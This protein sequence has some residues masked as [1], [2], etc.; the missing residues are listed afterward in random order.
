MHGEE[1]RQIAAYLVEAGDDIGQQRPVDERRAVQG[2]E[3]IVAQLEA[4]GDC[5]V[6]VAEALLHRDERVDHR[7]ADEVHP[8][9][10][11]ALGAQV[12]D[13]LLAMQEQVLGELVG[14]DAVDLL[15][16][17]AVEGAQARLQ[18]TIFTKFGRAP[19]T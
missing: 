10:G 14:D 2:D 19:T 4:E 17:R 16:H 15:G 8:L 13:R 3:Q 7:V 6:R 18:V 11:D 12:L 5:R 1:D 9:V